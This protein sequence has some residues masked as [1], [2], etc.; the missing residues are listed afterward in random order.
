MSIIIVGAGVFGLS[1]AMAASASLKVT[2]ID[3]LKTDSASRAV[4][5]TFRT[6]YPRSEY[7]VLAE[8]ARTLW[9]DKD[10]F[11][12]VSRQVHENERIVSKS[13][14]AGWIEAKRFMA[15]LLEAAKRKV[16]FVNDSAVS[17]IWDGHRC[18]GVATESGRAF[19]T[20]RILLALGGGLPAFLKSEKRPIDDICYPAICAWLHVQLDDEQ[21][22]QLK[23]TPIRTYPGK[24]MFALAC[25][26]SKLTD[27]SRIRAAE[28]CKMSLDKQSK[29]Y[30]RPRY[31]ADPENSGRGFSI[32]Q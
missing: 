11:H 25:S 9:Q 10:V 15:E 32:L 20:D 14:D 27:N 17:L 1:T 2:L 18:T 3:D 31:F 22:E 5:R 30:P 7:T 8:Q 26:N 21:Y 29:D 16:E 24:G 6:H 13:H 23:D 4:G 12:D 19:R 28:W